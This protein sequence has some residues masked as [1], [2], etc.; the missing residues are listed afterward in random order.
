MVR[1]YFSSHCKAYTVSSLTQSS[2]QGNYRCSLAGCDLNRRYLDGNADAHP[3]VV[4][5]KE[6]LYS[7]QSS[8]GIALFLDLHGHSAKKNAFVYGCDPNLTE[9]R[10]E[11][12]DNLDPKDLQ[13]RRRFCHLFPRM[14][15]RV[16]PHFFSF[17]DCSFKVQRAKRGT[18]RVFAWNNVGVHASYTVEISFCGILLF[19][20]PSVV[21]DR[22]LLSACR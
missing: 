12:E 19:I 7:Q 16:S 4:A 14:L 18:G 10:E 13:R 22:Q 15:S 9:K 1:P 5:L 11:D 20:L 21:F 3:S 6:L 8:R 17:T 2:C